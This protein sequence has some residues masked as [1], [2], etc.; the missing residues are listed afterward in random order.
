MTEYQKFLR[1]WT[2]ERNITSFLGSDKQEFLADWKEAK[3]DIVR[4]G[5]R[6]KA[7]KAEK[8]ERETMGGEDINRAGEPFKKPKPKPKPE[9]AASKVLNNPDLM[10]LIEGYKPNDKKTYR[11]TIDEE[12]YLVK[13]DKI[14]KYQTGVI[15]TDK[16]KIAL[17]FKKLSAARIAKQAGLPIPEK[18]TRKPSK[19]Q[20]EKRTKEFLRRM[21]QDTAQGGLY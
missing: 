21:Q 15:I 7:E 12:D 20:E 4:F 10:K 17:L 1:S 3:K 8:A 18:K 13:G 19:A 9:S 14:A 2:D 11:V 5:E 16:K 6:R